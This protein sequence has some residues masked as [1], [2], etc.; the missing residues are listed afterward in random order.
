MSNQNRIS[1]QTLVMSAIMTAFVVVFQLLGTYTAFFGPFSTAVGL[2]PIAI[3]A[4]LCGPGVGAWLGFVFSMVVLF[5]G[6]ANLF[7]AFDVRGTIITVIVKGVL[8]GFAS[9]LVYKMLKNFNSTIAAIAAAFTCP[10]VNTGLFLA[11]CALF[12]LDDV[13]GIAEKLNSEESGMSLFYMLA[14][15]NFIFELGMSAVVSPIAV[16][17]LRIR[18]KQ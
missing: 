18:K 5:T 12:L 13:A 11:G 9:G 6:G 8:C 15:A 14:T 7:L 3:G 1:T 4:M 16:K 10:I 2:I 17:L